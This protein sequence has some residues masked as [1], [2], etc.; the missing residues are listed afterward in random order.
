MDGDQSDNSLQRAG[1]AYLFEYDGTDWI[2]SHYLK[3]SV[4]G[5]NDFFGA[6]VAM[7]ETSLWVTA[8]AEDSDADGI[9]E[10]ELDDSALNAGAT[11]VFS[12]APFAAESVRNAGSNPLSYVGSKP[13]LGE[14]MVATVDVSM[15][16]HAAAG[17]FGFSSMTTIPLANGS[18][19]L[20][21]NGTLTGELL[22]LP[23]ELGPLATFTVNLPLD[24]TLAGLT[25]YTQALHIGGVQPFALSN[26]VDYVLGF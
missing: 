19:L 10:D 13:V 4:T 23:L 17:I 24:P 12:L 2:F 5:P 14:E 11:Y 18:T 22:Q 8:Y 6:R 7:D 1:A 9:N 3:P 21:G 20:V 16:G 15:T 25:V 26:A